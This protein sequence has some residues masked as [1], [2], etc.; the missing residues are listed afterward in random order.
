MVTAVGIGPGHRIEP[1]IR[2]RGRR[3]FETTWSEMRAFTTERGPERLD[4]VWLVEHPP[5][6][7]LGLNGRR[8]HIHNPGAIPVVA[9][10]RGGQV[11]YHGP[12]Q[13]VCYTLVDLGRAGLG[14]RAWVER[15][16]GLVEWLVSELGGPTLPLERRADAP[17]VYLAGRKLASVGLRV[18]RGRAYHGVSINIAM[19]LEPFARIDPCGYPGQTMTQLADWLGPL[20]LRGVAERLSAGIQSGW[21]NQPPESG[22]SRG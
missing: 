16:E 17:G 10:D 7:T 14:V 8:Q 4:E 12:G 9:C 22:R 11:T 2:W 3:D 21:L 15:L 20:P 18:R 1:V 5:V 19:D 6:F 13:L